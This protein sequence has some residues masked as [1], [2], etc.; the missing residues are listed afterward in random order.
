M[1]FSYKDKLIKY[2]GHDLHINPQKTYSHYFHL[3]CKITK[4]KFCLCELYKEDSQKKDFSSLIN[5][6]SSE[7]FK[8][9]LKENNIIY[10][11]KP[12]YES[13]KMKVLSE[14]LDKTSE[15]SLSTLL[16][17][18]EGVNFSKQEM[19]D[20]FEAIKNDKKLC[21]YCGISLIEGNY[22]KGWKNPETGEDTLLCSLCSKKYNQGTL[23]RDFDNDNSSIS[24]NT[25]SSYTT[26]YNSYNTSYLGGSNILGNSHSMMNGNSQ[27]NS[28][29]GNSQNNPMKMG[30][31][32]P[33]SHMNG[34]G[35][36]KTF[37]TR[38]I[39][40]QNQSINLISGNSNKS[41]VFNINKVPN[42]NGLSKSNGHP[43][44][45]LHH[46]RE[47]DL[48]SI[49]NNNASTN[50]SHIQLSNNH[51]NVNKLCSNYQCR[52]GGQPQDFLQCKKCSCFYHHTC[53]N[54]SLQPNNDIVPNPLISRFMSRFSWRCDD[55]KNCC[56]C[57]QENIFSQ[58][59]HINKRC[60][61]CDRAY[62][63]PCYQKVA[64][65]IMNLELKESS[66]I[67]LDCEYCVNCL[68]KCKTSVSSLS[69]DDV[70]F[71]KG[72]RVC[73]SCF[74]I[75]KKPN[76]CGVCTKLH[77][78]ETVKELSETKERPVLCDTNNLVVVCSECKNFYHRECEKISKDSLLT[79]KNNKQN[80]KCIICKRQ[81][82]N[83]L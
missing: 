41:Q 45:M 37:T 13:E 74:P 28:M 57:G 2:L 51:E 3:D 42:N 22:Y 31:S 24:I 6:I 12:C 39:P 26:P 38:V 14:I 16:L 11:P 69:Q 15:K 32:R 25:M 82:K 10:N 61:L 17:D 40:H 8:I 77:D 73:L 20:V 56:Y 64:A 70:K 63:D 65:K 19:R 9:D 59:N 36:H 5:M 49:S 68:Q 67:C 71:V 54:K 35:E 76:Y 1:D 75:Y 43:S 62:H 60:A 47:N 30:Y 55:C 34:N 48:R 46:K 44:Q 72:K 52:K 81:E 83:F 79:M 18:Y 53:K 29:Y 80:Y 23:E 66:N 50:I 78:A 7:A 21:E 4:R 58:N 27:Y 33:Y